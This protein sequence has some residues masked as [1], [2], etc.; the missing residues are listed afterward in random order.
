MQ[1]LEQAVQGRLSS[2]GIRLTRGRRATLQAIADAE[3]PR[4]A[5]EIQDA[6]SDAIPL[7]SLYRSLS[8]LADAGVLA[9]EHDA[10]GVMRFELAE[11]LGGHHHHLVCTS[12][13]AAVD[14]VPNA[15]QERSIE[16]LIEQLASA[17]GFAVTGH[18]F[19]IEG[20][21]ASCR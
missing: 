6:L 1:H 3:G 20:R 2:E 13:G 19:E 16:R 7:S 14:V 9:A 15:E 17:S 8:V 5:A 18:R 4:T 11:W 12:C 21:C 10:E